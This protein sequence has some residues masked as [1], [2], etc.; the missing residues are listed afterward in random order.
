M[1]IM[2]G[3]GAQAGALSPFAPTG[4]IVNGLMD[5]I[6][7]AGF[8]FRTYATNFAAHVIV[9]FAG[10]FL[11]GGWKLFSRSYEATAGDGSETPFSRAH[12]VTIAIVLA[13]LGAVLFLNANIG[14]AAFTRAVVLGWAAWTARPLIC[15]SPATCAMAS[16]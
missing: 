4:I 3:N 12:W 16:P 8:E 2:V 5:K 14:M 7:L 1:A 9:A 6:G 11:L 13:M 15:T 10:Y